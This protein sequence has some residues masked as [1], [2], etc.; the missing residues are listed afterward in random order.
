MTLLLKTVFQKTLSI[1]KNTQLGQKSSDLLKVDLNQKGYGKG[2][3]L[4]CCSAA[5][6]IVND[7]QCLLS[8]ANSC[9]S[10]EVQLM[11][12]H[13][14]S[15]ASNPFQKHPFRLIKALR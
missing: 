3:E 7:Q 4:Q 10:S 6:S 12:H 8:T 13:Q 1:L 9:S 5:D 14:E 2:V 15:K 11:P